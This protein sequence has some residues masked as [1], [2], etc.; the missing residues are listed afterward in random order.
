MAADWAFEAPV[1]DDDDEDASTFFPPTALH[2]DRSMLPSEGDIPMPSSFD[3]SSQFSTQLSTLETPNHHSSLSQAKAFFSSRLRPNFIKRSKQVDVKKL[4]ETIWQCIRTDLQEAE[5]KETEEE[6]EED[7]DLPLSPST[8]NLDVVSM[9]NSSSTDT[10]MS[11]SSTSLKTLG[12]GG[13]P[14]TPID[15]QAVIQKVTSSYTETQI[16]E[17][18]V[19]FCFVCLLHLANEKNLSLE[20]KDDQSLWV[21]PT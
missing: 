15:F 18:S 10:L 11:K 5:E 2:P 3:F 7:M 13:H 16:K 17:I 19:P 6:K 12:R 9:K 8:S 4:K 21:Y 1:Q 20:S 14:T